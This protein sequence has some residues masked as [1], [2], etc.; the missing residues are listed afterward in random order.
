MYVVLVLNLIFKQVS[1]LLASENNHNNSHHGKVTHYK[2]L[3][4]IQ[5]ISLP[6]FKF[7]KS[8]SEQNKSYNQ[9]NPK[10]TATDS[11]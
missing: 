6:L 4:T 11:A 5:S 2:I 1:L 3:D 8:N 9:S 10:C 7:I